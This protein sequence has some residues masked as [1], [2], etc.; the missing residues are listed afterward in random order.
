[1]KRREKDFEEICFT[2]FDADEW[3]SVSMNFCHFLSIFPQSTIYSN[4]HKFYLRLNKIL[5]FRKLNLSFYAFEELEVKM[6][7]LPLSHLFKMRWNILSWGNFSLSLPQSTAQCC[8]TQI[9]SQWTR[10][11]HSILREKKLFHKLFFYCGFPSFM[12]WSFATCHHPTILFTQKMGFFLVLKIFQDFNEIL[13]ILLLIL[14]LL[15]DF[16]RCL[17]VSLVVT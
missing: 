16:K 6:S 9:L 10:C 14:R 1:M 8:Q 15:I 3:V 4:F 17:C 13:L 5:A 12:E 2:F 11:L 7:S